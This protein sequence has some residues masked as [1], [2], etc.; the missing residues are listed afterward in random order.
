VQRSGRDTRSSS[1]S[2]FFTS[3][4]HSL[5]PFP[6]ILFSFS[7]PFHVYLLNYLPFV[8]LSFY[9]YSFLFNLLLS[10]FLRPLR[11][12][13]LHRTPKT[14][15]ALTGARFSSTVPHKYVEVLAVFIVLT[16]LL[17]HH[18]SQTSAASHF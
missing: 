12:L 9:C 6:S 17:S 16:G 18:L 14:I 7:P 13:R 8:F 2:I 1:F 3:G 4:L 5:Y 10:P 11:T 15:V